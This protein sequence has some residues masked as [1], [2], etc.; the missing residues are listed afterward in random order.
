MWPRNPTVDSMSFTYKKN[1]EMKLRLHL[2]LHAELLEKLAQVHELETVAELVNNYCNDI[3][4]DIR[5]NSSEWTAVSPDKLVFERILSS[6]SRIISS[7]GDVVLS[8]LTEN[9]SP[10][11]DP[12]VRLRFFS[13]LAENLPHCKNTEETEKKFHFFVKHIVQGSTFFTSPF[14]FSF[15]EK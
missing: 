2:L 6:G 1:L 15:V 12:E 9:L 7:H 5:G 4:E 14:G 3:L 11:R 8:I 10:K 13:M